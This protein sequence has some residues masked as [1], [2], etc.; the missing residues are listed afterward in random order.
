MFFRLGKA[1][2]VA[3]RNMHANPPLDHRTCECR[4]RM[5]LSAEELEAWS[6]HFKAHFDRVSREGSY[7]PPPSGISSDR[8]CTPTGLL[9]P[10]REDHGAA[11]PTRVEPVRKKPIANTSSSPD[12]SV[13][14]FLHW[15]SGIPKLPPEILPSLNC[16]ETFLPMTPGMQYDLEGRSLR[17]ETRKSPYLFALNSAGEV[18]VAFLGDDNPPSTKREQG[19]RCRLRYSGHFADEVLPQVTP[20]S[21]RNHHSSKPKPTGITKP[22]DGRREKQG[23][24]G[25]R[26]SSSSTT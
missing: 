23:R 22:K 11:R 4:S 26:K 12:T 19:K 18:A 21:G 3:G 10:S 7:E 24:K 20:S 5:A 13:A 9:T 1:S 6:R 14:E 17:S 8:P 16:S 25:K 2:S 15:L